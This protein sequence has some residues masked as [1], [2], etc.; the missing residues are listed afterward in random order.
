M[1]YGYRHITHFV[2]NPRLINPQV[3]IKL[4]TLPINTA[5]GLFQWEIQDP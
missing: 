2:L 4:G 1:G 5:W 3:K